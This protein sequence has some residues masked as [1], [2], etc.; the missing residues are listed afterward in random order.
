MRESG[1]NN[2]CQYGAVRFSS[3]RFYLSVCVLEKN[4]STVK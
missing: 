4:S 2:V 1:E 3:C